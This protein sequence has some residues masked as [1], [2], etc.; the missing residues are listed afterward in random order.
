MKMGKVLMEMRKMREDF[1]DDSK[2]CKN[3]LTRKMKK[4]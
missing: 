4:N 1:R 3:I 2:K